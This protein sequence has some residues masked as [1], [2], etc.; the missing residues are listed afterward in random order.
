MRVE[1]FVYKGPLADEPTSQWGQL[2]GVITSLN[3]DLPKVEDLVDAAIVLNNAHNEVTPEEFC[4]TKP[5]R[6]FVPTME[7]TILCRLKEDITRLNTDSHRLILTDPMLWLQHAR[8]TIEDTKWR[9]RE[10]SDRANRMGSHVSAD[11]EQLVKLSQDLNALTNELRG[12]KSDSLEKEAL[13]EKIEVIRGKIRKILDDVDAV[14]AS[15]RLVKTVSSDFGRNVAEQI[16]VLQEIGSRPETEIL[17]ELELYGD[18]LAQRTCKSNDSDCAFEVRDIAKIPKAFRRHLERVARLAAEMRAMTQYWSFALA[19][20]NPH[21]RVVRG[22]MVAFANLAAQLGS[23][24]GHRS[25]SLLKQVKGQD[26]RMAS[27]SVKLRNT[28]LSD[29]LNLY[30]WR[31]STNLALLEDMILRPDTAF[32]SEETTDRVRAVER[33]YTSENWEKINQVYASGR[34]DVTMALIKDEIGNWDLKS[35]E[36]DPSALLESYT[37]VGSELLAAAAGAVSGGAVPTL[38]GLETLRGAANLGTGFVFPGGSTLPAANTADDA[39]RAK[40]REDVVARLEKIR[41][42]FKETA[43]IKNFG[44]HRDSYNEAQ[45]L[46]INEAE[47]R[48]KAAEGDRQRNSENE[49]LCVKN[50]KPYEGTPDAPAPKDKGC[51]EWRTAWNAA[52]AKAPGGS[53]AV[54]RQWADAQENAQQAID[55]A[56]RRSLDVLEGY[57]SVLSLFQQGLVAVN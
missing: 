21:D 55:S 22:A 57:R 49:P 30:V 5:A 2:Q 17:E 14:G 13:E 44:T 19:G 42:D 8:S 28:S 29:F 16:E 46:W 51:E 27:L 45:A 31:R 38:A 9:L 10:L 25:D 35:F 24:L 40:L 41:T 37:N 7:H 12:A 50:G 20:M 34:G 36:A 43:A 4:E 11:A 6:A 47:K 54:E 52:E 3:R 1:V 26:R 56:R 32:S 48:E 18:F 23:Q 53:K 33:L 15:Q 39:R